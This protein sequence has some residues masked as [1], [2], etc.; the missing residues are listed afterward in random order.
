MTLRREGDKSPTQIC[1]ISSNKSFSEKHTG[2]M[3]LRDRLYLL[4]LKYPS[5]IIVAIAKCSLVFTGNN[6]YM[7]NIVMFNYNWFICVSSLLLQSKN[8][9]VGWTGYYTVGV[10]VNVLSV[11]LC[12]NV[13]TLVV[14][15]LASHQVH[16][17]IVSGL[18]MDAQMYGVKQ[19][20]AMQCDS[21]SILLT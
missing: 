13:G 4:S 14:G 20:T 12:Y 21:A 6:D 17:G 18:Q 10:G 9:K 7:L 19:C 5:F 16:A 2:Q 11:T 3:L 8:V 15:Y 1:K